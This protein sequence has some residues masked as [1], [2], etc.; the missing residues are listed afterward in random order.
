MEFEDW[1]DKFGSWDEDGA[2]HLPDGTEIKLEDDQVMAIHQT[3]D[4]QVD[5]IS[6]GD[7][8]DA[9]FRERIGT[10]TIRG[11]TTVA[12]HPARYQE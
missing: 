11:S 3:E 7:R 2:C 4:R 8:E 1:C 12:P 9:T 6:R 10:L 5:I